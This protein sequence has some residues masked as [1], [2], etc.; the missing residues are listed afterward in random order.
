MKK[1]Q[2]KHREIEV[3]DNREIEKSKNWI[4][5]SYDMYTEVRKHYF[6]SF[7]WVV[8]P[9]TKSL[10]TVF[11]RLTTSRSLLQNLICVNIILQ[12]IKTHPPLQNRQKQRQLFFEVIIAYIRDVEH[13]DLIPAS[14]FLH[15]CRY[16]FFCFPR[17]ENL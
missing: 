9:Q 5:T 15:L 2:L 8:L 3:L 11:T 13:P 16:Y 4:R 6:S 17:N 12:R 10:P 7:Y 14:L 1:P